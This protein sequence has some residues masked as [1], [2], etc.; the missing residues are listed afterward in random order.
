VAVEEN[1]ALTQSE[2]WWVPYQWHDST[3]ICRNLNEFITTSV[4]P[5]IIQKSFANGLVLKQNSATPIFT[6]IEKEEN[7]QTSKVSI[8]VSH[9]TGRGGPCL[10]NT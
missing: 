3:L 1:E 5:R 8:L 6:K 2:G 7:P 10:E 4:A 9:L